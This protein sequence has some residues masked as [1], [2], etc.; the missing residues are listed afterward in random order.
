MVACTSDARISPSPTRSTSSSTRKAAL[1]KENVDDK[2]AMIAELEKQKLV[3][4]KQIAQQ[5]SEQAS[6]NGGDNITDLLG[7]QPP[8]MLPPLQLPQQPPSAYARLP[9]KPALLKY[10]GM[11]PLVLMGRTSMPSAL[12]SLVAYARDSGGRILPFIVLIVAAIQPED[13]AV[14]K[15]RENHRRTP[16][17]LLKDCTASNTVSGDA[18]QP[19]FPFLYDKVP[20]SDLNLRRPIS[21]DSASNIKAYRAEAQQ[22]T[23]SSCSTTIQVGS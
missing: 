23:L 13:Y 4:D 2:S 8:Q 18:G 5:R 10:Q 6:Y 11:S 1:K 17:A 19:R 9:R 7:L 16:Q 21:P 15:R 22:P 20:S 3:L 12:S 14:K